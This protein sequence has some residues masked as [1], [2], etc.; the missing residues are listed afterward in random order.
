M[1]V[2]ESV[3]I[4]A[5]I[6]PGDATNKT[7]AWTSSNPAIATVDNDGNVYGVALGETIV[8]AKTE[9]GGFEAKCNVKVVDLPDM[10]TAHAGHGFTVSNYTSFNL[11]LVFETNTDIPV[12]INSVILTDKNG[13]IVNIAHPNNYYTYFYDTYTTHSIYTPN[14]ISGDAINA[15]LA[16][17]SGW[18]ILVQYTWNNNE[19][20]VEC[21]NQ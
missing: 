20:T 3:Q 4:K 6:T 10:V 13:I 2:G 12:Y 16:K 7:V 5:T 11:S 9:D 15:E 18:K 8:T 19:Y 21:I 14:G 1:I 17:I